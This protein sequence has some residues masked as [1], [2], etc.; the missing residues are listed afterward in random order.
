VAEGIQ[1]ILRRA[2]YPQPYE[3]LKDLT[4]GKE[5]ITAQDIST[6]IEGLDV[7]ED[8]KVQLRQLTPHT[9]TG[10]DLLGRVMP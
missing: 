5:R 8:V 1:T 4:R 10:I 7:G 3:R 9:Y 2:G 6:F